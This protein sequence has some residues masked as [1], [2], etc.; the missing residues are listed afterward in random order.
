MSEGATMNADGV[1]IDDVALGVDEAVVAVGGIGIERD[2]G[3]HPDLRDRVLD[4]LDR[5][6]DQVVGV[7]RFLGALGA[8]VLGRVR[9]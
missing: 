4:R 8:Q 7:E 9:E 6:A 5:A 2:V 1:V 3:Q